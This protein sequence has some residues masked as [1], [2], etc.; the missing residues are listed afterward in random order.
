MSE[1]NNARWANIY[2][3]MTGATAPGHHEA[4]TGTSADA[5]KSGHEADRF[6]AKGILVVPV[7]V[8][9]ITFL[10]YLMVTGL[11]NYIAMGKPYQTPTMNEAALVEAKKPLNEQLAKISLNDPNAPIHQ[12]RLEGLVVMDQK[13]EGESKSDPVNYRSFQ[14]VPSK[15]NSYYLTPQDLYPSRFVDPLTGQRVLEQTI[16]LS[17]DKNI[18]RIPVDEAIKLLAGKLPSKKDGTAPAGSVSKPK[19]SNGGQAILGPPPRIAP[20]QPKK[21]GH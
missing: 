16:W 6:D 10:A 21:E 3:A 14:P 2:Q 5:I 9:V 17:K 11:F 12:S 8:V 20:E 13:R 19:Q 1:P 7:L 4:P 15:E 18:A